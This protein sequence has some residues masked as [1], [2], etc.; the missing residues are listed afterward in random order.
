MKNKVAL[1]RIG[2]R[3]IT[4]LCRFG[5]QRILLDGINFLSDTAR[6]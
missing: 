1:L 2:L 6:V 3:M 5:R 4:L